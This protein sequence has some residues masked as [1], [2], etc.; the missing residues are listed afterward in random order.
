MNSKASFVFYSFILQ[1]L[2]TL[3]SS[4]FTRKDALIILSSNSIQYKVL[5][6]LIKRLKSNKRF[7]CQ[8]LDSNGGF[9]K[10]IILLSRS[11]IIYI[12]Q[13]H[14]LISKIRLRSDQK[15]I[16]C[17]HGGG[18]FKKIGFDNLGLKSINES[19][20]LNRIYRNVSYIAI[21]DSKFI[22]IFAQAFHKKREQILPFGLLR[23]DSLFQIDPLERRKKLEEK[24]PIIKNKRLI[25]YAPTYR[26]RDH[27]R[28]SF[29]VFPKFNIDGSVIAIRSHPSLKS[30][31]SPELLNLNDEDL[32][33][34]LAA[35]DILVTDFS[36]I[37]FDYSFFKRPIIIYTPDFSN[38]SKHR[39]VYI[40]IN[41]VFK[42]LFAQ[43]PHQL[44][45]LLT[46]ENFPEQ[47]IWENFMQN[48]DGKSCE[49][50]IEF[51]L[52]LLKE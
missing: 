12:D 30:L 18:L 51:S 14:P 48:C 16:H 21:S 49:R 5:P 41:V 52:K 47:H 31:L 36:S 2:Y 42:G 11:K 20:R 44:Y 29:A 32:Y 37:L 46:S 50:L 27:K 39:G 24:Y 6:E 15:V 13:N 19:N 7:P 33:D 34:V 23:T 26:E 40:D 43:N 35:T 9:F 45:E 25:L 10:T 38:Y 3:L 28:F 17:W 22:D 4:I 8:I 1:F